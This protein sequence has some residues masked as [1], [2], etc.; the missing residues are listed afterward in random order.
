[1]IQLPHSSVD[2]DLVLAVVCS[3]LLILLL[4]A[5]VTIAFFMVGRHKIRQ[6]VELAETRLA[7][8]KELRK[9]ETEISEAVMTHFAQELHDNIGQ[10][11]TALHIR[12]ENI[13]LDHPELETSFISS[14]NY[15]KE[16]HNQLRLLSRTLSNDF[17]GNIG[18]PAALQ[19]ECDRIRELRKME[20]HFKN[21]SENNTLESNQQLMIFR[22]FQEIV[23]NALRHSR[24]RNLSVQLTQGGGDFMLE[25]RDDGKGFE[26]EKM[27][28]DGKAN[29]LLNMRKRAQ[30]AGLSFE[31]RSNPGLGSLFILKRSGDTKTQ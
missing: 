22:I 24:A 28:R 3:T 12:L 9:A 6:Q 21:E 1:V 16:I 20:V 29:G 7:F 27:I 19:L 23:Q 26:E 2:N 31:I 8:E 10:M 15:V 14:N 30:L 25:V 17:V 4:I 5:G 13:K 11:L 18:L